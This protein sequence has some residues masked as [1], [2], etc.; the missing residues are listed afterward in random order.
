M[1]EQHKAIRKALRKAGLKVTFRAKVKDANYIAREEG[2]LTEQGTGYASKK[3]FV[4]WIPANDTYAGHRLPW[5]T[6]T[7]KDALR[8]EPLDTAQTHLI[9]A[10]F[11]AIKTG[12]IITVAI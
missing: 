12:D 7:E 10:G 11:A 4:F 8:Q 6:N 5:L 3:V 1:N 9:K 2:Y